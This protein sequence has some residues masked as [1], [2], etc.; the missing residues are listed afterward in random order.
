MSIHLLSV[1]LPA[2]CSALLVHPRSRCT[3]LVCLARIRARGKSLNQ[4]WSGLP[5]GQREDQ[6]GLG[7]GS[8]GGDKL[9]GTRLAEQ[10]GKLLS[11]ERDS[12][13]C[14]STDSSAAMPRASLEAFLFS[15]QRS[16]LLRSNGRRG[17]EPERAGG[18][19]RGPVPLSGV[20]GGRWV[21]RR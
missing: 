21:G 12:W 5:E 9:K 14:R 6:E 16:W 17:Q 3:R 19:R 11:K 10:V 7:E 15:A 20:R 4:E 2:I 13:L 18:S 1:C 8:W